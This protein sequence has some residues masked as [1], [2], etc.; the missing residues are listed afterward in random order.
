MTNNNIRTDGRPTSSLRPLAC[1]LGTL[2]NSDG[3]A[4]WKS[5]ATHV[6]ASVHGPLAPRLVQQERQ[7]A[8]VSVVIKSG[9]SSNAGSDGSSSAPTYEREWEHLLTTTLSSAIVLESYPRAVI[10]IVIQILSADGSIL[11]ACLHAAVSA[12][13]DAGVELHFLPTASTCL[14]HNEESNDHVNATISLDPTAMEEQSAGTLVV[15]T[16][17]DSKVLATHTSFVNESVGTLLQC[18]AMACRAGPAIIAFWRLVLEQKATREDLT[19][20]AS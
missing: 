19:L 6:L 14:I 13:L 17:P 15:V 1:E 9:N 8:V 7:E 20:W 16:T 18:C 3:S 12:L 5:G 11:A 2:Q 10:Q 4:L